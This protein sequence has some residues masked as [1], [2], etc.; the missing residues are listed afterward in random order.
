KKFL[1]LALGL[2]QT[3][4]P[5]PGLLASSN[6]LEQNPS[7]SPSSG[8]QQVQT[9][10]NINPLREFSTTTT[11]SPNQQSEQGEQPLAQIAQQIRSALAVKGLASTASTTVSTSELVVQILA[12]R[13]F[14]ATNSAALGPLGQEVVDTI[15]GVLQTD[16]NAVAVEGYTDNAPV[17]GAPYYSNMELSAVRAVNV[18]QRLSLVDGIDE[19]RLSAI[20]YGESH[21]EVPNTSP[22]NMALNRRIDVVILAPGENVP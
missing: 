8:P 18:V 20:G 22:A 3:F 16:T 11:T 5:N 15:A 19:N 2:R 17:L 10:P 14:F 6:G 4:N 12:D 21:P 7:L 1:A 13:V 9:K